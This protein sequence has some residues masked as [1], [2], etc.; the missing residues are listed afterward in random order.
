MAINY[1]KL[2][3]LT[4][5]EVIRALLADGFVLRAQRGSHR[6]YHHSDGRR[7]T[8]PFHSSGGTFV[9]KTLRSILE[10]QARWT[11]ADLKRLRLLS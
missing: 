6:R 2:R 5:R 4:A 7:V 3:S 1:S 10:E 8:V 9:P 11:E